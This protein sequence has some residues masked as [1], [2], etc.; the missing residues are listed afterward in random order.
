MPRNGCP[1]DTLGG[2][3][4]T[5]DMFRRG[6]RMMRRPMMRA[7]IVSYKHQRNENT[8]YVGALANNQ[9]NVYVGVE[10]GQV[11][12][13]QGVAAGNKVYSVNIS[14]NFIHPNAMGTDTPSWMLVYLRDGQTIPS[15]FAATAASEWSN[16][17]LSNCRNQVIKSYM[18]LVGTEDAGPKVWNVHIKI[19]KIYQRVRQGDALVII[20]TASD[21]GPLSIGTR[22]K[23]FS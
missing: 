8:T 10:P 6:R 22:F 17:G 18:S 2:P 15:C 13:P 20:F 21:S 5:M 4:I 16:I 3:C 1:K 23:S 19:P 11:N 9:Y 7:P 12:T 14:L